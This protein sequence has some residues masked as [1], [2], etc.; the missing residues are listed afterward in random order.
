[1]SEPNDPVQERSRFLPM[2]MAT[3]AAGFFCV[4]MILITG[5][6][7]FYVVAAVL[8]LVLLGMFHYVVWGR[9]MDREAA[10]ERQRQETLEKMKESFD[11]P[12][13]PP[14]SFRR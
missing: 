7:F 4:V 10:A 9:S 8:G 12:R 13:H 11:K 14:G 2:L 6:F 1:M 3:L 5:G